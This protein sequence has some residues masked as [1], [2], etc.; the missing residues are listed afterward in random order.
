MGTSLVSLVPILSLL[1][2]VLLLVNY[3]WPLWDDKRQT[4]N[5][6]IAATNVVLKQ[7][8]R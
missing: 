6:K 2:S 1:G 4:L 7:R 5:D 3:L 8:D